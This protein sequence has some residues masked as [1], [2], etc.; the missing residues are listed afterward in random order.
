MSNKNTKV[1][2]ITG[3]S[4]GFGR[5]LAQ[6]VAKRG[7]RLIA[8]ARKPEQLQD[9]VNEY[10]DTVKAVSQDVT[11]PVQVK[12]AVDEALKAF[13]QIDVLVNNAGIVK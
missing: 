11:N 6:A 1:W 3:S 8:T 9:L 2:L 5:N 10:P 13:G 4:S 7:D 12:A